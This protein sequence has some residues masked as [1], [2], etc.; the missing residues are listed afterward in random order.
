MNPQKSKKAKVT[1][2]IDISLIISF[3]SSFHPLK[4]NKIKEPTSLSTKPILL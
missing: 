1:P 3:I 2:K 4:E